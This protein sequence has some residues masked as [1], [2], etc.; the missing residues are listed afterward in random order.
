MKIL[1]K[2]LSLLEMRPLILLFRI[3]GENEHCS[4]SLSG[5]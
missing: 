5:V 2:R 3:E 1:A 4:V